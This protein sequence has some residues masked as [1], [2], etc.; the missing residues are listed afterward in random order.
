MLSDVLG[1]SALVDAIDH[2]KSLSATEGTVL[3]P[4]HTDDARNMPNGDD[5]GTDPDGVPLLVVCTLRDTSGNPVAGAKIDVWET[6]SQGFYDVQYENRDGP[7]GRAVLH[8]DESGHFFFKGIVPVSY[9]VPVDGP[10]G[11]L[12]R[13]LRRHPYRPAHMHFMIDAKGF[14]HFIR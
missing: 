1:V 2:P 12:L 14:D 5:I 9:P 3:G 13:M 11:D 6:D 10:V 7:H 8:S 4:F